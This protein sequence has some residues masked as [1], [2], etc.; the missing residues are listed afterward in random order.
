MPSTHLTWKRSLATFALLAAFHSPDA[1][2]AAADPGKST[3]HP[4]S[5]TPADTAWNA[6][7]TGAP[8]R[9]AASRPA[10]NPLAGHADAAQQAFL[11]RYGLNVPAAGTSVNTG[12]STAVPDAKRQ[13]IEAKLDETVL[14]E[15]A[16]D[17]LPL[18][19]VIKVLSDQSIK[20]DP[21][22]KGINFLLSQNSTSPS[23]WPQIDPS[24]GLPMPQEQ[25]DISQVTIKFS[26][27][28]R[29]VSLK[30]TLE[31]V[32][33]VADRPIEYAVEDYGVVISPNL[34]ANVPVSASAPAE[35]LVACTFKVDTNTFLAG[36]ENAFGVKVPVAVPEQPE[37]HTREIQ[38]ALQTLLAQL[39][40]NPANAGTVFYNDLTGMVMVRARQSEEGVIQ[41]VIE[42][43][44]G[45]PS[46]SYSTGSG[47]GGGGLGLSTPGHR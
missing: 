3:P 7:V 45:T 12:S 5:V 35:Q 16:F 46:A 2:E 20:L 28:L 39:G 15:I 31:A 37:R 38:T 17:G 10:E 14:P 34:Q 40:V 9:S 29:N 33:R 11:R 44:G 47:S 43:L 25:W 42:T 26:L 19:D 23:P 13:K 1:A 6:P 21:E 30:D 24:T 41:A 4:A 8:P 36:L 22:K 32:V 18:T 27:P